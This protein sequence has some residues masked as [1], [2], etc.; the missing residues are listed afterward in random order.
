MH[1]GFP[2]VR[3]LCRHVGTDS[4][5]VNT[6][7]AV[8]L[9][10]IRTLSLTHMHTQLPVHTSSMSCSWPWSVGPWVST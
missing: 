8:S 5:L 4:G 9:C 1:W 10:L 3:A 6:S 2:G 7:R